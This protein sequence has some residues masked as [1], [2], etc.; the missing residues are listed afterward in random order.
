MPPLIYDGGL[1]WSVMLL[2]RDGAPRMYTRVLCLSQETLLNR[3]LTTPL[4]VIFV[5]S[6]SCGYESSLDQNTN[7]IEVAPLFP[8]LQNYPPPSRHFV[9]VS[10]LCSNGPFRDC[11]AA[12]QVQE[13]G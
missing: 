13:N 3:S 12:G 4:H 1:F 2:R 6:C 11:M 9:V 10:H 8:D 5:Q 7:S